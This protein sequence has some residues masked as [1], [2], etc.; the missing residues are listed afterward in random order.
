MTSLMND[1]LGVGKFVSVASKL[2]KNDD[3][4]I[5]I[6]NLLGIQMVESFRFSIAAY[7]E[8]IKNLHSSFIVKAIQVT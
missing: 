3:S 2:K 1:T 5:R 4:G 7:F 8:G 6:S